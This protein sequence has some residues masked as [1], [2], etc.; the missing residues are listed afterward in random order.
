MTRSGNCRIDT[1]RTGRN[2]A[3]RGGHDPWLSAPYADEP[4]RYDKALFKGA[5]LAYRMFDCR[6][7]GP[8]FI[9]ITVG[10]KSIAYATERPFRGDVS[11]GRSFHFIASFAFAGAVHDEQSGPRYLHP[12]LFAKERQ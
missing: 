4:F 5:R 12:A 3:S 2:R 9:E 10:L 7:V 6:S 1:P 8:Y 11:D